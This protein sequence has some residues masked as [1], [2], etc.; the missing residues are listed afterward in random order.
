MEGDAGAHSRIGF[1]RELEAV[2]EINAIARLRI[3]A[4]M[5]GAI[6]EQHG[7]RVVFE[8]CCQR[9]DRWLVAGHDGD[10]PGYVV[11]VEM[12]VGRVVH[13]LTADE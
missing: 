10:E 1:A 4:R 9:A 8:H 12:H 3:D 6:R 2:N 11:G 5:N 7:R 13:Q